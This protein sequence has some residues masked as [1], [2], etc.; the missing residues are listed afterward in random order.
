MWLEIQEGKVRTCNKPFFQHL[1]STAAC[2]KRVVSV[3][4]KFMAFNDTPFFNPEFHVKQRL[5]GDADNGVFNRMSSTE[6]NA[7]NNETDTTSEDL[8][9]LQSGS[10]QTSSTSSPSQG[11]TSEEYTISKMCC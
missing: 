4:K 7:G 6:F 9:L 8:A 10:S 5:A 11:E 1:G 3:G 2:V